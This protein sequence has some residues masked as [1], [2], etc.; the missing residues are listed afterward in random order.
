[1]K[2]LKILTLASSMALAT[3]SSGL[4]AGNT[5]A[6]APAISYNWKNTTLSLSSCMKQAKNA[7]DW[8]GFDYIARKT[9][10]VGAN[11]DEYKGSV[12]CLMA[13]KMVLFVVSGEEFSTAQK[14]T[15][16]LKKNF[17]ARKMTTKKMTTNSRRRS[18][19]CD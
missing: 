4:Y 15:A 7:M 17:T 5:D 3:A 14:L 11:D 1:M 8:A 9:L 12:A 6:D 2:Y 18:C 19:D 16:K 13:K 10:V